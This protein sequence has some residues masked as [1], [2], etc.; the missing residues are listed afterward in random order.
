MLSIHE[1]RVD[2]VMPRVIAAVLKTGRRVGCVQSWGAAAMTP[3]S[4]GLSGRVLLAFRG[5]DGIKGHCI[6]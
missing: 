3:G 4:S 2:V 1:P 6:V 5:L